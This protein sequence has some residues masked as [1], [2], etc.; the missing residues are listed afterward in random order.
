MSR[1]KGERIRIIQFT[2]NMSQ[3]L[4]RE[5]IAKWMKRKRDDTSLAIRSV[6]NKKIGAALM[7]FHGET[8]V[9]VASSSRCKVLPS[10]RCLTT[11]E[12]VVRVA[13]DVRRA[14]ASRILNYGG[15]ERTKKMTRPE[16]PSYFTRTRFTR[17]GTWPVADGGWRERERER[18]EGCLA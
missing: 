1:E 11:N 8:R 14:P 5:N 10:C 6:E 17:R 15:E 4:T 16:T 3:I 12:K 9:S 7:I 13:R 18:G 2:L